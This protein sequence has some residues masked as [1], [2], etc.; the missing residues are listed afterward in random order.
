MLLRGFHA[1]I[2]VPV[3]ASLGPI[4]ALVVE[5]GL[6]DSLLHGCQST[7]G[8]THVKRVVLLSQLSKLRL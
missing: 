3:A 8:S 4:V 6:Y 2:G 1:E 5:L 7:V